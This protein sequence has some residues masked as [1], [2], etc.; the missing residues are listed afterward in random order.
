LAL[1]KS[2]RSRCP[3]G[4]RAAIS[5]VDFWKNRVFPKM[6]QNEIG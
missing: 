6:I 1:K 3:Q 4:Q 5:G 2:K